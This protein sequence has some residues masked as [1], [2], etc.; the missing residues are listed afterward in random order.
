MLLSGITWNIPRVTCI[1]WYIHEPLGEC[2]DQ[3]NTSD[4]WDIPRLFHD[5][6]LHNYFMPCHRKYSDPMGR[7]GVTQLN[8]TDRW[9]G[10]VEC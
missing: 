2:V 3:E 5:K 6:G 10:L 7:L 8:C 9:E 4:E 1:V